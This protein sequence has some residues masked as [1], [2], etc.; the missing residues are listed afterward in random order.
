VKTIAFA[1]VTGGHE[2]LVASFRH[3]ERGDA[4]LRVEG[5]LTLEDDDGDRHV[6]PAVLDSRIDELVPVGDLAVKGWEPTGVRLEA[7]DPS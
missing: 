3:A 7:C 2:T 4:H 1:P 5:W 6:V